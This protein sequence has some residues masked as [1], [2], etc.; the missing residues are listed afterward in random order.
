MVKDILNDKNL[1]QTFVR[2]I[3]WGFS[4][5]PPDYYLSFIF[6]KDFPAVVKI[7]NHKTE[8]TYSHIFPLI[9]VKM[10]TVV[11]WA[12]CSGLRAWLLVRSGLAV[13]LASLVARRWVGLRAGWPSWAL[14]AD[15]AGG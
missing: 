2:T 8:C 9:H 4:S 11:A 3:F 7:D 13:L 14:L 5:L 6:E 1:Y 15:G 12:F 10:P